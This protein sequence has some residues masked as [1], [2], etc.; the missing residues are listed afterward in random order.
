MIN[1]KSFTVHSQF[2][3]FNHYKKYET[4]RTIDLR[5]LKYHGGIFEYYFL[6]N[7]K[8]YFER[9]YLERKNKQIRKSK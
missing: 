1:W 4:K 8:S 3:E 6:G 7:I 5:D 2:H 9:R